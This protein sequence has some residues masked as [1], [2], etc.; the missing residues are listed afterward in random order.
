MNKLF[1]KLQ[2]SLIA[3]M[4]ASALVVNQV[5]VAHAAPVYSAITITVSP[6]ELVPGQAGIVSITGGYPLNISVSL[7]DQ[8]QE[9]F[10][11]G[12]GYISVFAAGLDV[13]AGEHSLRVVARAPEAEAPVELATTIKVIDFTYQKEQLVIPFR[14]LPLLDQTLN[15]HELERLQTIYAGRSN[16]DQWDW[17][18]AVPVP[19]GIVTSRFGGD[20]VY[21]GGMFYSRHTG[22]D[23]RRAIGEP[24]LSTAAGRVVIAELFDIHGNVVIIDHG[25]GIFSQY[26][27][28][29]EF[30]VQAGQWVEKGQLL[31]LA[32]ATGR[33][34]GPHLH[35][36]IIVLGHPI[37][38]L[39]WLE[40]TP[41]F[42]PPRE[43]TPDSGK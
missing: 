37:D 42:I 31:G 2:L 38:P 8:P 4:F 39:K 10:W 18:F 34:N 20:R 29:N 6:Q 16:P 12:R 27:H 21:N 28:L 11:T 9:V 40:L 32:G 1:R 25:H 5:W 26:A 19:A 30:A 14:L 24:I 41:G 17:P 36:E 3:S 15:D 13:V 22:M 35:F 7:D 43:Y 23:F 33:T